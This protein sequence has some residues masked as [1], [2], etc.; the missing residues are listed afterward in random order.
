MSSPRSARTEYVGA[1][2]HYSSPDRRDA[3]KRRWEEPDLVALFGRALE[4]LRA[5][6]QVHILDIGC[7]PGTVLE[8][9]RRTPAM[10]DGLPARYLGLDLDVDLLELARQRHADDAGVEFAHGDVRDGIPP[11]DHDLVVSSGVPW[12]HLERPDLRRA[13]QHLF[14]HTAGRATPTVLVI[15]VLGR[16]SLEWIERW[17]QTRW[18]YR[19]S[20]FATEGEVPHAPMST[21]DGVELEAILREAAAAAGV[22]DV[23]V[24]RHDRSLVVGRHT[25]TGAYTVDLPRFRDLVDGLYDPNV[26]IALEGLRLDLPLADAPEA[27]L[28]THQELAAAW[29]AC[30]ERADAAAVGHDDT[31]VAAVLEP[32]L[33][34]DLHAVEQRFDRG[35]GIGHSLTAVVTIP[36]SAD[37]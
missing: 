29:N 21:Y 22:D 20:F 35:L 36:G 32:A 2:E 14:T 23:E 12:S 26:R 1:V 3:V 30:L 9:L 27:V 11:G 6:A 5:R 8:L 10:T 18:D 28:Q 19:M 13:V 33:A 17:A 4:P 16:Y 34:D 37:G 24:A 31:H 25:M 15:D 7:G